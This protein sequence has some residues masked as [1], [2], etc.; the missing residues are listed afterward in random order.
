MNVI[1]KTVALPDGRTISIE[2]GKLAKQADGSVVV[3][4]GNTMLLATVCC[5]KDAVP[6]T[7]F[8]PLTVEYKEKFGAYGRFPGGFTKREGKASDY[9]ILTARLIDRALRP[10]FPDNFHAETFVNVIMVSADGVDIPD[11]LA[12]L[13]ASAALAVSDIPFNGPIS[14]VRV[15]R[16]NGEFVIDPTFEQLEKADMD[17]MVGATY[18]NIMM[19]EGEM[20]EVSEQDLLNA[21]KAAHEAIKPMC[22]VQKEL[23][24]ELG[25]DVKREY[26]H[27]E[28][29]EELEK[30]VWAKCYDKAYALASSANTDKHDRSAKFEAVKEE[31][32]ESLNLTEE[33]LA[34]KVALID[35]YYHAVEKEAMRRS[36][37]DEGKRLDGRTTTEIRPIWCEVGY[38]P[39]PHGSSIF[40]RGETQSLTTCT[41]GTKSDEKLVDDV[42]THGKE[43][44]LLHYN[45]PPFSTGEAKPQRG[46]G[47]REIGHGHL[48]WR[49]LKGMIPADYPYC[50]R[51]VSDI[52][53]SN[54]S[55]SMATVC[56]GTLALMDAGVQ[57]KKPVSGIAMGLITDKGNVKYSVLSDILGDEDHLGDM[58]FKVTGTR[59]GI[60]ATQMDIKVDG[61]SYEILEKALNQAKEGRLHIL[62]KIQETIAE[63]RADLKPHA[64]RIVAFD[65]PKDMIGAI[66]GPGGKIIQDIQEKSGAT[67]SI[68]EI[69]GKGRVEVA[70]TNK[71]ALDAAVSRIKAIVAVPEVGETYDAKV[72]SIMPYG[73]FV[74]FMPGKEG[75]L[76]ISEIAWKRIEKMEDTGMKE[77]D[78]V[79]VKLLDIDPKS[80]KFKLSHKALLPRPQREEKKEQQ[81]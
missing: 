15:A 3:R 70:A 30:D 4:M 24:K 32:I 81:D 63:P 68:D 75:L 62:D 18:E 61:L 28:S 10:L 22:L 78:M 37:L 17:L 49:A 39:G 35:R 50:V 5:A 72:K 41:L 43:R 20:S 65:V 57:I 59:D 77:G 42:L 40:T 33:E 56:A 64:P 23:M 13:A 53:E 26:C 14:E 8:M 73:A 58:D 7:D 69:D 31:Y 47:R 29:D 12:G 6:G 55:S 25:T 36:I 46:V 60:T 67:V 76:H 11:A 51:V 54:G 66:I 38:L 79:Q 52:M 80:G 45:F 71:E 19:V 27:E 44:F 74:E 16:I 1:T 34:D 2:T 9:E 48:A 21:L